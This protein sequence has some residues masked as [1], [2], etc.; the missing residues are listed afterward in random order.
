MLDT[1]DEGIIKIEERERRFVI[2][3]EEVV[4]ARKE[5]GVIAAAVVVFDEG[6]KGKNLGGRIDHGLR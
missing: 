1:R 4:A 2:N 3:S 6:V 5:V